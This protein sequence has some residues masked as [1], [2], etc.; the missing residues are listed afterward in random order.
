MTV[1]PTP[2]HPARKLTQTVATQPRM[3]ETRGHNKMGAMLGVLAFVCVSLIGLT[4]YCKFEFD[5]ANAS[6]ILN[7]LATTSNDI[8]ADSVTAARQAAL[9]N[10]QMWSTFLTLASWLSLMIATALTAAMFLIVR[11]RHATPMQAL[12]QSVKNL[13]SGDMR[14]AIWGMER[15]DTVGEL[16]RAIDMARYQLSQIPDLTILSEQGPLRLRFEGDSRSVFEA[17]MRIV[18]KDSEQVHKHATLLAETAKSQQEM[19]TSFG[20]RIQNALRAIEEQTVMGQTQARQSLQAAMS[21]AASLKSAQEHA[22]DQLNRLVPYMQDRAQGMTEITQIAG[23]QV[24]QVVQSLAQTERALRQSAEQSGAVVEKLSKSADHLGERMF[25]AVNLLQ[26]SGKVL[27]EVSEKTQSKIQD[28]VARLSKDFETLRLQG[29]ANAQARADQTSPR[30]EAAVSALENTRT[31]LQDVLAEQSK[32]AKAQIEL[33]LTQSGGLLTQSATASQTMSTVSDHMRTEQMRFNEA[34]INFATRMDE[35]GH[36]LEQQAQKKPSENDTQ[37]SINQTAQ[38]EIR[39]SLGAMAGQIVGVSERLSVLTSALQNTPHE[40]PIRNDRVI[41]DIESGF[42][43]LELTLSEMRGQLDDMAR[44]VRAMPASVSN[45]L[46]D[47]WQQVTAQIETTREGLTQIIMQQIDRL[48]SRLEN[49]ANDQSANSPTPQESAA[50][51]IK[52]IEHEQMEQQ[53]Q[54]LS[55]LVATL[56]VLDAHMQDLR[57]QISGKLEQDRQQTG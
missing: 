36:R 29:L 49:L 54:V 18:S 33:L 21:I 17:M 22:T 55:E 35:L 43:S 40:A 15:Q 56:G 5:Q 53:V 23:K 47:N 50:E 25:G 38:E 34:V 30:L 9:A 28:V 4:G 11:A 39:A 13:A 42:A 26:A 57:G 52:L 1:P 24:S 2:T 10:S 12:V 8:N 41:A 6:V 46:R 32:A 27:A 44:N 45:A 20:P 3:P 37:A 48:S 19:L 7:S 31:R 51:N 14:T 16:A